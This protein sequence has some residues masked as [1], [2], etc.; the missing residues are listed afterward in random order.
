[1]LW[2]LM[3]IS[4]MLFLITFFF[5][6]VFG[7]EGLDDYRGEPR[8]DIACVSG[9][10]P[11]EE[12]DRSDNVSNL[13]LVVI[14]GRNSDEEKLG[15]PQLQH[16]QTYDGC[17][18]KILKLESL[19]SKQPWW[20]QTAHSSH[21]IAR[22]FSITAFAHIPHEYLIGPGLSEMTPESIRRLEVN[23]PCLERTVDKSRFSVVDR[24]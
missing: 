10:F 7:W 14:S 8:L 15:R 16:N 4:L 21:S 13:L 3:F 19:I 5:C 23:N 9:G 1:M 11:E 6:F 24:S 18:S 22:W 17:S 12:E 2:Q 20:N